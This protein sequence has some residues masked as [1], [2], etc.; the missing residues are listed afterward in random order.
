MN[1]LGQCLPYESMRSFGEKSNSSFSLLLGN[2]NADKGLLSD[3]TG[4]FAKLDL[5]SPLGLMGTSLS[6]MTVPT[7][8]VLSTVSMESNGT[9]GAGTSDVMFAASAMLMKVVGGSY[10]EQEKER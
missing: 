8:S 1:K 2:S 5:H 7:D 6:V 4:V 9:E 10:L 3:D